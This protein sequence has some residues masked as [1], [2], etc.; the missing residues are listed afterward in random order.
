M[1]YSLYSLWTF[2]KI[3]LVVQDWSR[4][5]GANAVSPSWEAV[6]SGWTSIRGV[7]WA[8]LCWVGENLA[9]LQTLPQPFTKLLHLWLGNAVLELWGA[10]CVHVNTF[11][12]LA[13]K[14]N[15]RIL[16]NFYF[17]YLHLRSLKLC[18]KGV[19]DGF[20]VGHAQPPSALNRDLRVV[21]R[22]RE[23]HPCAVWA[24]FIQ[25]KWSQRMFVLEVENY[26][27][28]VLHLLICYKEEIEVSQNFRI[29]SPARLLANPP[30]RKSTEAVGLQRAQSRQ[31]FLF[32]SPFRLREVNNVREEESIP[33]LLSGIRTGKKLYSLQDEKEI[34]LQH[35]KTQ[36]P[37]CRLIH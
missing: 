13:L 20:T 2:F 9:Q 1:K 25:D 33:T 7:R 8:W 21:W 12:N 24:T 35:T 16:N 22:K 3:L 19:L 27:P 32:S 31:P 14:R 34:K 17:Q 10:V 29:R 36:Y 5:S 6:R 26:L 37:S 18:W 30:N 28:L 11:R 23:G 15:K 4:L